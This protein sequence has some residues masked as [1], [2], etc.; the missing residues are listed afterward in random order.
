MITNDEDLNH[1]IQKSEK[2][3]KNKRMARVQK[4]NLASRKYRRTLAEKREKIY[5]KL[6]DELAK[7]EQLTSKHMRLRDEINTLQKLINGIRLI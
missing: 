1:K 4:N 6:A 7:F 2:I 3:D 5:K